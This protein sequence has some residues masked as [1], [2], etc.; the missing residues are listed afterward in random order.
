V[1]GNA[2]ATRVLS[3]S[4]QKE[5][6]MLRKGTHWG[7]VGL[8][9]VAAF[10]VAMALPGTAR[11]QACNLDLDIGQPTNVTDPGMPFEVNDVADIVLTL[12]GGPFGGATFVEVVQVDYEQTCFNDGGP[13]CTPDN[14]GMAYLG[15][16]TISSNCLDA[17]NAPVSWST[18]VACQGGCDTSTANTV[19]FVP[20]SPVELSDGETCTLDFHEEVL[21]QVSDDASPER[22]EVAAGA[23]GSCPENQLIASGTGTAALPLQPQEPCE[24]EIEKLC[25]TC[26]PETDQSDVVVM[27]RN[28][29]LGSC[30][31]C[32]VEDVFDPDGAPVGLPL[33]PD[34]GGIDPDDFDLAPGQELVFRGTTP[35]L[36]QSTTDEASVTCA[37]LD[38]PEE[39][40]EDTDRAVCACGLNNFK[41]YE[42]K[43]VPGTPAF[44]PIQVSLS[45]QFGDTTAEAVVP[46][47]FCTPV[48]KNGEGI[49]DPN[50]HLMC[51]KLADLPGEARPREDLLV[52]LFDQFFPRGEPGGE[53]LTARTPGQ[54]LCLPA[55]KQAVDGEPLPEVPSLSEIEAGLDHY[56]CYEALGGVPPTSAPVVLADQFDPT[57][58]GFAV[59]PAEELCNPVDKNGGD[60]TP[61]DE[62]HLK[63][64]DIA[65]QQDLFP[66][67]V[68]SQDQFGTLELRLGEAVRLCEAAEKEELGPAPSSSCGL[69]GAEAL[70]LLGLWPLARRLRRRRR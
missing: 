42:A 29:G 52:R 50:E 8:F 33:T 1:P 36:A 57:G 62:S 37:T 69:L 39:I 3:A 64:Y 20:S 4:I 30:L 53:D 27:V 70:G 56:Q 15:D 7:A 48:D 44:E 41:C 10:A 59:A 51:Y 14:N 38:I 67:E 21:D 31:A 28:N 47:Q 61:D 9:A 65:G 2:F 63:C 58:S 18:Q 13:P 32:A 68:T 24:V 11:S 26:D 23:G 34:L 43:T 66:L 45:D 46:H 54:T 12:T 55:A 17:G 19:M 22:Y 35:P 6:P 40:V 25:E 60:T 5:I 16:A 49:E